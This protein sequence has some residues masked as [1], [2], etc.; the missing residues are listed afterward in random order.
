[1]GERNIAI[2]STDLDSFDFKMRKTEQLIQSVMNKLQKHG[3][4]IVLMHDFQQITATAIPALLYQLRAEGY[5]V[6]HVR[7]KDTAQT[8]PEYDT[9]VAKELKLPT[10]SEHS[11]TAVVRTVEVQDRDEH[12]EALRSARIGRQKRRFFERLSGN[13]DPTHN[14]RALRREAVRSR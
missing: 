1:L 12:F 10:M 14:G 3:K 8:L 6:V 11:T 13:C 9:A 2:F 5:R 7:A 4:G